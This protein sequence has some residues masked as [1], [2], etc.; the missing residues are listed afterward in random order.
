MLIFP[1]FINLE[2][3]EYWILCRKIFT[4][5]SSELFWCVYPQQCFV[6]VANM[7]N[8]AY[9]YH[10]TGKHQGFTLQKQVILQ[11]ADISF[12]MLIFPLFI[13]L[14]YVEYWFFCRKIF[15]DDSS[16][17]FWCVSTAVFCKCR[18]HVL[19]GMVLSFCSTVDLKFKIST[20]NKSWQDV[21]WYCLLTHIMINLFWNK[22]FN[23]FTYLSTSFILAIYVLHQIT[24]L[25]E[26][27]K[28]S[29]FYWP[30]IYF[31]GKH[32]GFTLQKQVISLIANISLYMLKFP[33]FINIYTHIQY[34]LVAGIFVVLILDPYTLCNIS[35]HLIDIAH[36]YSFKDSKMF[37]YYS[38]FFP[39]HLGDFNSENSPCISVK[40]NKKFLRK[41]ILSM[42]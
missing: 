29:V 33:L 28:W 4:D 20:Q 26:Y 31:T 24:L 37:L 38:F 12:S 23:K 19:Y 34:E 8:M 5:D 25:S 42:F 16:E 3:V 27:A 22:F 40:N 10:F 41:S 39:I 36:W 6:N 2:Y 15:T 11:I 7:C 35:R 21:H 32:Q 1:L 14:E 18:K 13:N 9:F 17:L 30:Q